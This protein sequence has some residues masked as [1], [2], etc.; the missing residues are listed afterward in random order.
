MSADTVEAT[1]L[2]CA[3]LGRT[4]TIFDLAE[5]D[6]FANELTR[7]CGGF[8]TQYD[9]LVTPTAAQPPLPLGRLD[10]DDPYLDADGWVR[11]VFAYA[12]FTA[13][14]NVSGQPAISLPL[15][16]TA[17]GLPVGVQLVAR[18]GGEDLLLR[19]AAQLETAKP[20]ISRIPPVHV[21]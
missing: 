21:G 16:S 9:L 1:V 18:Y 5:A 15:G 20:W 14:F 10:A 6:A 3:E 19:V 13:L 8:F 7:V 4:F 2:R 17:D 11:K 12:A